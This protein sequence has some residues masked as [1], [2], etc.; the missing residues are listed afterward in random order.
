MENAL[1]VVLGLLQGWQI[2]SLSRIEST[3]CERIERVEDRCERLMFQH[4]QGR[5]KA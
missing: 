5:I 4:Q 3:L 2:F 1:L